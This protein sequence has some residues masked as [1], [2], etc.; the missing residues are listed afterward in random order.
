M[1]VIKTETFS[2]SIIHWH[3]NLVVLLY[4]KWFPKWSH[5][6]NRLTCP[7]DS[8]ENC[9][10]EFLEV[11]STDKQFKNFLINERQ[12]ENSLIYSSTAFQFFF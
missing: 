8:Q 11:N 7:C 3:L 2:N 10:L 9:G 12:K 1:N 4:I 5:H 6:G